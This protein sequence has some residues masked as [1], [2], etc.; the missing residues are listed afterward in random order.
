MDE[1]FNILARNEFQDKMKPVLYFTLLASYDDSSA[2]VFS[3]C[4]SPFYDAY[5]FFRSA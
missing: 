3:V 1:A 5:A 2:N 4:G